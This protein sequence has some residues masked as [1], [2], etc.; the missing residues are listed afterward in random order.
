[1]TLEGNQLMTQGTDQSKLPLFAESETKFFLKFGETE[2]EF[3][4]NERGEITHLVIY[5]GGQ[6][7]KAIKK[8]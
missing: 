6:E 3:F 7:V 4:K 8:K 1:M 2:V 5:Q